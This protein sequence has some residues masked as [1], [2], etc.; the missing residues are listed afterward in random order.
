MNIELIE[1]V[2]RILIGMG[3]LIAIF[4]VAHPARWLG[5]VGVVPLFTG[6][7][8]WCPLYAWLIRD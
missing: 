8:G 4:A 3:M 7:I 5:I 2:I 6:L 1:R